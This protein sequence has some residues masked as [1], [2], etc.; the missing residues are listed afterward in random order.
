MTDKIEIMARGIEASDQLGYC[1]S[2]HEHR[3]QAAIK[4]LE[5]NG[6]AIVQVDMSYQDWKSMRQGQDQ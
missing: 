6:F 2:V 5:A 3:A 1:G 4:A